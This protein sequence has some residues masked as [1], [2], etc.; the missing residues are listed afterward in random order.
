MSVSF[1]VCCFY[2]KAFHYSRF[3]SHLPLDSLGIQVEMGKA[4]REAEEVSVCHVPAVLTE[5]RTAVDR[6]WTLTS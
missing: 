6:G 4:R 3:S 5:W 1:A 2:L